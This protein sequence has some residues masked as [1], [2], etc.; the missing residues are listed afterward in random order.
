MSYTC[1]YMG[2]VVF[3]AIGILHC[4]ETGNDTDTGVV[5]FV[6]IIRL[7]SRIPLQEEGSFL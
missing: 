3:S 5:V 6:Y 1:E 7:Q 2:F 4:D